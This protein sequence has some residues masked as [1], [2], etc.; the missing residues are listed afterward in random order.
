MFDT[1]GGYIRDVRTVLQDRVIPYRYSTH[2][3]V[4]ALN[5]ALM[6]ARRI[7]PDLFIG[8]LD[9]VPQFYWSNA[10]DGAANE[11]GDADDDDNPTWQE[12]VP[13]DLQFRPAFVAGIVSYALTRD[14]EDIEDER[15][16]GFM[17]TFI[18]T[19]TGVDVTKGKQPPKV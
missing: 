16:T 11:D 3:L 15:A 8:Y 1:V 2:S 4:R 17:K 19:L 9:A 7:R 13:M 18:N 6:D 14:Q 5:M 10:E 12:Y